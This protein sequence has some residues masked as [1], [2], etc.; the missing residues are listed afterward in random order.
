MAR[1]NPTISSLKSRVALCSM[2][3][4]VNEKGHM[5]L[6]RT[7]VTR[8]WAEITGQWHLPSFLGV[9][10]YAI[11]EEADRVT[12]HVTIRSSAC[13]DITSAA[14]VYEE[15]RKGMPRWYKVL[16]FFEKD[17]WLTMPCHLVEKSDEAQPPR[18]DLAPTPQDVQ[19]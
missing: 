12:H 8:Q 2:R 18:G 15:R 11:K 6:S 10:G 9:R 19:L 14:W 3:D 4:V 1:L 16:G 5:E 7:M 17:N 13:L